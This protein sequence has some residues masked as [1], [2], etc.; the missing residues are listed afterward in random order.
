MLGTWV[1][2]VVPLLLRRGGNNHWRY[3]LLGLVPLLGGNGMVGM[4]AILVLVGISWEGGVL[5]LLFLLHV[6]GV[7]S[8]RR[9]RLGWMLVNM[10]WVLEPLLGMILLLGLLVLLV[11]VCL[12]R[13]LELHRW[14]RGWWLA[15]G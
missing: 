12:L 5:G 2:R 1:V 14:G 15:C 6:S 9:R 8:Y 11:L 3:L 4:C 7:G 13:I 10:G